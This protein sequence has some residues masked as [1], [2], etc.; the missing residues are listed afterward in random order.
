MSLI[1]SEDVQPFAAFVIF[2]S[3]S[4]HNFLGLGDG[5]AVHVARVSDPSH[6]VSWEHLSLLRV[7][8]NILNAVSLSQRYRPQFIP[9]L[10][11]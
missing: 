7:L 11:K 10:E 9:I 3:D 5:K 8:E 6:Q 4:N 1:D 2:E